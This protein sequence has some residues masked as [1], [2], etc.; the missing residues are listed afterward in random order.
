MSCSV[1]PSETT[2]LTPIYE[3]QTP[4]P[5]HAITP[6][7]TDAPTQQ[8]TS[9]RLPSP[10]ATET[11]AMIFMP[12]I[13]LSIGDLPDCLPKNQYQKGTVTQVIDGDTITVLLDDGNTYTVR[14]IGIDTPER[15]MPFFM[16]P[17]IANS[18]MVL[19]KEVILIKDVSETDQ[20]GR[21]LR[22]VVVGDVFVNLELVRAGFAQAMRYPPDIA[23]ADA[24][25]SAEQETRAGQVGIWQATQTPAPSALQVIII[26]V[27]KR[28][29]YVDLQ[30]VGNSD[31]DLGG[32]NLVSER[33]HQ[34]CA[35]SG[36][37]KAGETLRIW[38]GSPQGGGYSCEYSSPIWNNSEPDP[39]VLY[40]AQGV[41]VS[42]K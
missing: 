39:A 7:P 37:I 17:Y 25:S 18:D 23:C 9:T 28:E 11:P 4:Q 5:T 38:A 15:D 19:Q 32:W 8:P 29:E 3:T 40:N 26:L 22:Y 6:S 12:F 31:V 27:N 20:Y 10:T 21:L 41:E 33:G 24:F 34:E 13:E 16:E 42:R 2:A 1:A 36:M 30:N 14:Y 35:L